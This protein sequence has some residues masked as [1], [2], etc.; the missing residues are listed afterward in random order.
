MILTLKDT[1]TMSRFVAAN[2]IF[3]MMNRSN[4]SSMDKM[5]LLI[6]LSLEIERMAS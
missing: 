4:L 2:P 5:R 6:L 3:L 1:L